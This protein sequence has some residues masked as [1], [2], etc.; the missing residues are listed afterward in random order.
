MGI[1][2]TGEVEGSKGDGACERRAALTVCPALWLFAVALVAV[3]VGGLYRGVLL[4]VYGYLFLSFISYLPL[5]TIMTM[6]EAPP[7]PHFA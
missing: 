3:G 7:H 6:T 5:W 4:S 1:G 2:T